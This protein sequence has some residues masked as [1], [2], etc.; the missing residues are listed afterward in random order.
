MSTEPWIRFCEPSYARF[1]SIAELWNTLSS[2]AYCLTGLFFYLQTERYSRT[3][4]ECFPRGVIWRYRLCAISW[5]ILG[6]GS[7]AFHAN[8]T[9]PTEL[10]D[11]LGM[12]MVS[13]TTSFGLFDLH[14]LTTSRRA[15]WFYG[16]LTLF[17]IT[18]ILIYVNIMYHP[19][20]ALMFMISVLI[21]ITIG[22]TLPMNINRGRVKL[23]KE[24]NEVDLKA[25]NS[26]RDVAL[27]VASTISPTGATHSAKDLRYGVLIAFLGYAIWHI[28]QR[29]VSEGWTPTNL[30]SYE[31]DW[32]YW[33]HPAWHTLTAFGAAL[34]CEAMLKIR[35]ESFLS[36]LLRRDGTG[37]FVPEFSVAS[38]LK[39]LFNFRETNTPRAITVRK[40][41]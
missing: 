26:N 37:S 12:F 21:P 38:S 25:I 22:A 23:Y 15:N 9:V 8:Q 14:P 18:T 20:F 5:Q 2:F 3:F 19:F 41:Q 4:P 13:F 28:D 11:E 6:F 32:Y 1:D 33:C 16:A 29:C 7:A 24:K 10:W 40:S 34:T 30:N 35:V 27:E 31:L 39:L 36:P 17:V